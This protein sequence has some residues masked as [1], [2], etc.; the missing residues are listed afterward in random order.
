MDNISNM[1]KKT[2]TSNR[3]WYFLFHY[4]NYPNTTILQMKKKIH[5]KIH[6]K[7][8]EKKIYSNTYRIICT[9]ANVID[10]FFFL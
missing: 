7:E 1:C 8:R 2:V 9:G 6:L 4:I 10:F 3:L 5:L